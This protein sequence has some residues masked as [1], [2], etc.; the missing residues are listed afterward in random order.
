MPYECK[1]R[2]FSPPPPKRG[3]IGPRIGRVAKITKANFN[4]AVSS[5]GLFS[6]QHQ[7][8]ILL[9]KH[10]KLTVSELAQELGVAYS[11]ASV[12]IK[13][14]EKSGYVQKKA[15]KNDKRIT[16]IYLTEKG[17]SVPE[18]IKRNMDLQENIITKGMTE[19]EI[20]LLSDLLDKIVENYESEANKDA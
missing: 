20:M 9:M 12:S 18:N 3:E 4:K 13:R 7:I 8:I 17:K 6:G 15:D 11:T 1:G 2:H 14:M 19:N 5:E 10:Y 16:Y